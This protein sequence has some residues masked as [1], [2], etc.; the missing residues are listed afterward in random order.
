MPR[1]VQF[2]S[3]LGARNGK[4]KNL[5]FWFHIYENDNIQFF[6]FAESCARRPSRQS[7]RYAFCL[8]ACV[9]ALRAFPN[10]FSQLFYSNAPD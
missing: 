2:P 7:V 6:P 10:N 9:A 5:F 3:V 1:N 8:F 4:I